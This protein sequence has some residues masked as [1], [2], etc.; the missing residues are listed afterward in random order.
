MERECTG[1][2]GGGLAG[3]QKLLWLDGMTGRCYQRHRRS[4]AQLAAMHMKKYLLLSVYN[5]LICVLRHN[6][7]TG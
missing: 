1:S 3:M 2:L 7:K 4:G 6:M 5:A